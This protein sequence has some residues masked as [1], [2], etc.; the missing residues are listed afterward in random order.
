M[1]RN[2]G[3]RPLWA[4]VG[5]AVGF[6]GGALLALPPGLWL[7]AYRGTNRVWMLCWLGGAL[8]MGVGVTLAQ[9]LTARRT[10]WRLIGW[11][12]LEGAAIGYLPGLIGAV[13]VWWWIGGLFLPGC[14]LLFATVVS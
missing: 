8:G 9:F 4:V 12:G 14:F 13:G 1:S 11:S 3:R 7:Y 2:V 10:D 6:L 5:C